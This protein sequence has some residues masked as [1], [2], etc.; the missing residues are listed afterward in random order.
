MVE[1]LIVIA[2]IGSLSAVM[3]V[4]RAARLRRQKL[5]L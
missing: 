5:R 4:A 1:L 3:S 2:I